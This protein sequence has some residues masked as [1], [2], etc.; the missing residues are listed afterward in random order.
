[1][2]SIEFSNN[3]IDDEGQPRGIVPTLG[4]VIGAF[5]SIVVGEYIR[6]GKVS[7]WKPFNKRLL[8]RNYWEHII[9]NTNSFLKIS[10]YIKENP[11][12][13]ENDKFHVDI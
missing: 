10:N 7:G 5:K 9:R 13:W 2:Q 12:N 4:D 1:M 6:G 11:A 3:Q 8:Q